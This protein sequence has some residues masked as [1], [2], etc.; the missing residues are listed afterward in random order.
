MGDDVLME[1]EAA[2]PDRSLIAIVSIITAI[3]VIALV[4]VFTRGG[5]TDVD[6]TA[7]EGVVQSYSLAMVASDYETARNFLS[8]DRRDNC[9]RASPSTIQGL[10]MTVISSTVNGDSAVVRVTMDDGD[11]AFGGSGYSYDGVFFLAQEGGVWT[12]EST[13]WELTL[14]YDK[15]PGQ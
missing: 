8:S 3:V 7:P 1:P 11:G 5:P 2:R 4:V 6:P 12:I 13:P 9:D 14:C 10:R 15:G